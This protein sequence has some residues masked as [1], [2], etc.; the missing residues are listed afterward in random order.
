MTSGVSVGVP[1]TPATWERALQKWGRKSLSANLQPAIT[2][3]SRGFV[4]DATFHSQ[5]L[6]NKDSVRRHRAHR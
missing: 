2:I 1:G 5:T 4:V 6:D 3:A